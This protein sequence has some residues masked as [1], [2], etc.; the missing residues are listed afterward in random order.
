M[1]EPGKENGSKIVLNNPVKLSEPGIENGGKIALGCDAKRN[2]LGLE[3]TGKRE[4][5]NS[6]KEKFKG[7]ED[8]SK[9]TTSQ[10]KAS[11]SKFVSVPEQNDLS[12][13]L[14]RVSL[15]KRKT[16]CETVHRRFSFLVKIC[17]RDSA[18]C[19]LFLSRHDACQVVNTVTRLTRL[20]ELREFSSWT[21]R[22]Q[23]NL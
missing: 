9:S 21:C 6:A 22:S 4:A 15:H 3:K 19:K 13:F 17:V 12:Y 18:K 16:I 10:Q 14:K 20:F 1:S 23:K 7:K 8:G 11:E 5:R 2:E